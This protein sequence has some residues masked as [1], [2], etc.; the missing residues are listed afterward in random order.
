MPRGSS[1]RDHLC[2]PQDVAG[3]LTIVPA[4]ADHLTRGVEHHGTYR[5]VPDPARL[6]SQRESGSHGC[7]IR[8][9]DGSPPSAR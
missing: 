6:G 2:V 1:Q 7:G 3:H 8:Q 9:V 5:H 4:P